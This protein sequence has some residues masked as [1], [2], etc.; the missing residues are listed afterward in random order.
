MQPWWITHQVCIH[1]SCQAKGVDTLMRGQ[2]NVW[3]STQHGCIH[4]SWRRRAWRIKAL[5]V[6]NRL[7]SHT[8]PRMSTTHCYHPIS[9]WPKQMNMIGDLGRHDV[10]LQLLSPC[11]SL[12]THLLVLSVS[13]VCPHAALQPGLLALREWSFLNYRGRGSQRSVYLSPYMFISITRCM[14]RHNENITHP[15]H[16]VSQ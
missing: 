1:A 12:P 10:M 3:K 4:G 14:L 2:S 13:W 6:H 5:R 15:F 9:L 11:C 8:K 7:N 16:L